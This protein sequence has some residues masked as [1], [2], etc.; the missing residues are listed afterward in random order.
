MWDCTILDEHA[1]YADEYISKGFRAHRRT[2]KPGMENPEEHKEAIICECLLRDFFGQPWPVHD[3]DHHPGYDIVLWNLRGDAKCLRNN[4]PPLDEY[5]SNFP[6]QQWSNRSDILIYAMY[7]KTIKKMIFTGWSSKLRLKQRGEFVLDK[8]KS[9]NGFTPW[10]DTWMLRVNEQRDM[11]TL[12]P[13]CEEYH[14]EDFRRLERMSLEADVLAYI[15]G[16]KYS[17]ADILTMRALY[18]E[19]L[20][21]DVSDGKNTGKRLWQWRAFVDACV[22]L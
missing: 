21:Q 12:A 17:E 20:C 2:I 4:F 15:R 8:Q 16:R 5:D 14:R 11:D 6:A 9:R 1:R 22:S 13:F 18:K 19:V 7:N 10:G 3:V